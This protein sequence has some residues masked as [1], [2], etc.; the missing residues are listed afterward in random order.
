MNRNELLLSVSNEIDFAVSGTPFLAVE[1][2]NLHAGTRCAEQKE[3]SRAE[4]DY[5][6]YLLNPVSR[7]SSNEKPD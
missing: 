7:F 6:T 2:C 1:R 3:W 5:Q 4:I